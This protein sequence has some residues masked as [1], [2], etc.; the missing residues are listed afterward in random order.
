MKPVDGSAPD[1]KRVRATSVRWR[2]AGR[3]ASPP[4]PFGSWLGIV[5]ARTLRVPYNTCHLYVH[6]VQEHTST[7]SQRWMVD[8]LRNYKIP[9][10][11]ME[12]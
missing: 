8:S 1:A 3:L 11:A 6:T 5:G 9:N 2:R 7:A 4:L 10:D 12:L